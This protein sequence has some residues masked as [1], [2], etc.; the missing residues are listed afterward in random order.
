MIVNGSVP[1]SFSKKRRIAHK[2]TIAVAKGLAVQ[3][4]TVLLH[5]ER[6]S[7]WTENNSPLR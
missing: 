7:Q 2:R 5:E 6:G 1:G 3:T 4:V